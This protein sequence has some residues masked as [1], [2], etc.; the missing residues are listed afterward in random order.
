[1]LAAVAQALTERLPSAQAFFFDRVSRGALRLAEHFSDQGALIFFE[2]SGISTPK[3][4]RE[5]WAMAHVVKYSHERLREITDLDLKPA[6]RGGALLE[7]ETLGAE[8][9]RYRSR[10]T[11]C[12]TKGW[13]TEPGFT[14]EQLADAGGSGDW[15]SAGLLD[16]L[17]RSG[18]RG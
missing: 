9:L 2:P 14:V 10:L 15:C 6:E 1:I 5:A 8:G 12:K 4:F 3:L 16:K 17:G 7:I 11:S 13:V 18:L